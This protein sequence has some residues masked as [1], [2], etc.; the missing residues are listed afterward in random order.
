[1]ICLKEKEKETYSK[2]TCSEKTPP[3]GGKYIITP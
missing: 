3:R 2:I 1:V